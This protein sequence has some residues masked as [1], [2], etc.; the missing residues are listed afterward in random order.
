MK[1]A[2]LVVIVAAAI[3]AIVALGYPV[4]F[5]SDE[6]RIRKQLDDL[7]QT[8]NRPPGEGMDALA[9]AAQI[10]DVFA[11]DVT[12][13]FGDGPPVRGREAIIGIASRLQDRARTVKVSIQDVDVTVASDRASADVDLTVVV[14]TQD[15]TD[16]REFQVQMVKPQDQWLI[17]RATAVKVL[18]K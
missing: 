4:L 11:T 12:I 2:V 17:G 13:D 10:G 3:G 7:V 6:H 14:N 9:R 5:P 15:S 16:A 18:Q 1:Q 8:V